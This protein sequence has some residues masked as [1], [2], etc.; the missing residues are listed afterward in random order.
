MVACMTY[1]SN[2]FGFKLIL[3]IVQVVYSSLQNSCDQICSQEA[4]RWCTGLRT[5]TVQSTVLRIDVSWRSLLL[6]PVPLR[7]P[8]TYHIQYCRHHDENVS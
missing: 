7:S 3:L 4:E 8:H 6:V 2:L 5:P 1:E